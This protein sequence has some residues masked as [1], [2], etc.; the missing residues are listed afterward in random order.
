MS[1]SDIARGE[2]VRVVMAQN[3]IF[4]WQNGPSFDAVFQYGPSGPGDVF[5]VLVGEESQRVYLNGNSPEFVAIYQ[6]ASV[7]LK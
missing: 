3:N 5:V 7:E 2:K 4:P 6:P 1:D